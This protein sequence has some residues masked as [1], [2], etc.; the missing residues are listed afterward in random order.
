MSNSALLSNCVAYCLVMSRAVHCLTDVLRNKQ[1][2]DIDLKTTSATWMNVR[3]AATLG[4]NN[5]WEYTMAFT[6]HRVRVGVTVASHV[7]YV[8]TVIP[9]DLTDTLRG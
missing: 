9:G 1:V 4:D 2:S 8:T 3:L 7:L 5:K 6:P